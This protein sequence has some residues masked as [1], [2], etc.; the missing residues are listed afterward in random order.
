MKHYKSYMDRVQVPEELHDKLL[1]LEGQRRTFRRPAWRKYAA[2]AA[3]AALLVGAGVYGAGRIW[4]HS[5]GDVPTA[6]WSDP[7][8]G[9]FGPSVDRDPVISA[10]VIAPVPVD[11][12]DIQ[13]GMKTIPGYEVTENRVGVDVVRY[14][15]LPY[16]EY[17][18]VSGKAAADW[19]IPR[20]AARRDLTADEIAALLGGGDAVSTH[21]DWSG[22]EL[23]GWAAWREDGS[24]WG[25]YLHGYAG[26]LDHFEFAVTAGQLPPTCIV[27]PDS[28][29]QEIWGVT[30]TA[31][32]H[33]GQNGCDRRVS[34]MTD[35]FGYR[36]DL[37]ATGDPEA[38]EKLVSRVVRRMVVDGGVASNAVTPDGAALPGPEP[39]AGAP[40]ENN[41]GAASPSRAPEAAAEPAPS[42]GPGAGNSSAYDPDKG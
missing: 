15:V 23:T 12:D 14:Y 39:A 2:L 38:A 1:E 34:F 29:E 28:V 35:G 27:F 4:R 24:F 25:T 21:L 10:E 40:A 7:F 11:G 9:G 37:T 19:D 36:F 13:P 6:D 8:A 42:A 17:G 33:D 22:Y 16:I 32:K 3:C 41:G 18:D 20:G 31:D 30:V 5:V 26:P